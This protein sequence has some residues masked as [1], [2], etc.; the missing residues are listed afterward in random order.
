V[1][2]YEI[3]QNGIE[4][5]NSASK[6]INAY[7]HVLTQIVYNHKQSRKFLQS[8]MQSYTVLVPTKSCALYNNCKSYSQCQ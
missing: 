3:M 4:P 7:T 6:H 5:Y 8:R 2:A 1:D